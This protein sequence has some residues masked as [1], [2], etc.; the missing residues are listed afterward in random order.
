MGLENFHPLIQRWFRSR[1]AGP[2]EPQLHGWPHIA[3]GRHTLIAAPTGMGKTLTAFLAAIDRLLKQ[4][5]AGENADVLRV[6]YISP[7]RALSNDMQR[8]L[9]GPL[10]EIFSLAE[11]EGLE[12][13]PIRVGLRTG[14]TSAS[15]RAALTRRPPQIL[16][17]TP[18][19]L[20][21]LLTGKRSRDKLRHVETVIVDEIHALVRDKR[22]S[23]LAVSL[24]RL[25]QLCERPPQRVGLSATQRPIEVT[26]AFLIGM[27][28][29]H[30]TAD[31][32]THTGQPDDNPA[33]STTCRVLVSGDIEGSS[34]KLV[35]VESCEQEAAFPK[36]IR[37][38]P[39]TIQNPLREA[40]LTDLELCANGVAE[41]KASVK[42]ASRKTSRADF[43]PKSKQRSLF[44]W[45]DEPDN[46]DLSLLQTAVAKDL[47]TQVHPDLTG[48][49]P[50]SAITPS[51]NCID[52]CS[53]NGACRNGD[54]PKSDFPNSEIDRNLDPCV[55]V[56][57]GH[58]RKMDLAIEIP[59]TEINT[60]CT[61]EQ[62]QEVNERII[63]LVQQHRSTLI[64]VNT[65]RLAERVTH[66]LTELLGEDLIGSHHGSLSATTR[67]STEQ[68]LKQG[69]LK[70]VVATASLELGL[71]VG[72]VDL[73]IQIGSPRAIATFLQ[74]VGRS[75]HALGLI[76]KGRLFAL[77]RD[78][79]VEAMALM[80]AIKEGI[81]DT[82]VVPD[83]PLDILAQQIVA[84]VAHQE[85]QTDDLFELFR[86]AYPYRSLTREKFNSVI[87]MLSE[88][89]ATTAGRS[90]AYLHHDQVGKRVRARKGAGIAAV[91]GGGAIPEIASYRVVTES[92]RTVV[93]TVDEDFAVESQRGDVFLLGNTSW[94]IMNVR[95]GDVNVVDAG[96]APP[97]IPFW[98]GEAPGRTLELS[99]EVS[100][101]R[102]DLAELVVDPVNAEA[103][104]VSETSCC[105]EAARV[106]VLYIAA[107]KAAIGLVPTHKQVVY[108]RFFDESGGMQLVIHAPF[109]SRITRAWGMSMR[110]R[111]CRSF[112]FELQATADDDGIILSLGPQHSFPLESM[113]TMLN[114]GNARNL[115]EQA[116]LANPMYQTR[117]RWNVIRALQVSRHSGG[118]K[119]P[120]PLLR[121]R[122][123]DLLTAVFPKLTGCKE[124]IIGD[125]P[126][127]DHPL[128]SQT[129]E[130]CLFE[131]L[132]IAGLLQILQKIQTQEIKLVGRDT[133]EPSPFCYELLNANPYAFLDGGELQERR[134]RAVNTRRSL[135][136]ESVSDLGRLDPLAIEQVRREALPLIRDEDELHDA[137]LSRYLFPAE[138]GIPYARLFTRLEKAGRATL[139]TFQRN[140][141]GFQSLSAGAFPGSINCRIFWVTAERLPAIRA[142]YPAAVLHRDLPVPEGVK[143][144]WTDIDARIE[145][146]RGYLDFCGPTTAEFVGH[147]LCL[148][149]NQTFAALEYLEGEGVVLRGRFTHQLT[150]KVSAEF[151]TE[152]AHTGNTLV[153]S[154]NDRETA[155]VEWC[156]RRLLSRIHRLTLEGLRKEI[157]PVSVETYM[158]FLTRHQCLY[159]S[160]KLTGTNG[161]FQV[162]SQLQGLDLPAIGWE[163]DLLPARLEKYETGWLDEL[164]LTGEIGWG[165]LFPPKRDAD[166]S[167]PMA[168]ITRVAPISL[169]LRED[170]HFLSASSPE[171]DPATL[172]SPGQEVLELL[173]ERGAM[174][175][176]D[177]LTATRLLPTQLDDVLGELITH[178]FLAADGFSGLRRLIADKSAAHNRDQHGFRRGGVKTRTSHNGVGRWSLWRSRNITAM[179]VDES[180]QQWAWQLIRRWGV[181]FRELLTR[182]H[183]APKWFELVQVY[184]RLE[185]RGEI[186]GGRFIKGV[187]G[188]QFALGDTIRSLRSLREDSQAQELV[189][190]SAADPLNLVGIITE[191]PRVTSTA[192]NRVVYWNGEPLVA[193]QGGTLI[194]YREVP[195]EL[196]PIL[197]DRLNAELLNDSEPVR[198]QDS[199]LT[200]TD[201]VL[202]AGQPRELVVQLASVPHTLP[203]ER[204]RMNST[205][206][207]ALSAL[208]KVLPADE[209]LST[210]PKMGQIDSSA[211]L[212]I[213]EGAADAASSNVGSKS[214]S[215]KKSK[216]ASFPN[217]PN[218]IV[219]PRIS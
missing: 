16:V 84:E 101:L 66:Q 60:V 47:N 210:L 105:A 207:V 120:P 154:E 208:A 102:E 10:Q 159:G 99:A 72:A 77:T 49:Y 39:H 205:L 202:P 4:A 40:G 114:P 145:L 113:F 153:D 171:L 29:L 88:G 58:R 100:R 189:V 71:D 178:G 152:A 92:E 24:E 185:A 187:A 138:E 76:P 184:R 186:R 161:V 128:A 111:F 15:E 126:V 108:E 180:I 31:L 62:W 197:R 81:L 36:N 95:G 147:L 14:D 48:S 200:S 140:S 83:G 156:H 22:G 104:V 55:I 20:Y 131:P 51:S 182:E 46:Q 2:T 133:R 130:D 167:R 3:S 165:R 151:E 69:E 33:S 97:T 157:E 54:L 163:R 112:D 195:P 98:F 146:V 82:V 181:I 141:A 19:S 79:L 192:S 164:C 56:D 211:S 168:S 213:D 34:Q 17:T 21:L 129:M 25:T 89:I 155:T 65:R 177:I 125:I 30:R 144:D 173:L 110:K 115:L 190:I 103:W 27:R 135:T 175:A 121:F 23:H 9:Q 212:S 37:Q 74:R 194:R 6:I 94:R 5:I 12:I 179:P 117:W 199:V 43:Q 215:K 44:R 132:D 119:V 26:A 148:P 137:L 217:Y 59:K 75:G 18:E 28:H 139:V 162:L 158:R 214:L 109:G 32:N 45:D 80:R 64:F 203:N 106:V 61:H 176:A 52:R 150:A 91:M 38:Q 166:R 127:P 70:A 118:K 123:D 149:D 107:Q 169:F 218:S 209:P 143:G 134:A 42:P 206:P 50:S 122:S 116:V 67:H 124:E 170:I 188:E 1:F 136:V 174:F 63:E 160:Q 35:T 183:G 193:L 53:D 8:N 13:A 86:G 57:V 216:P 142:A 172:S 85:W 90:R 96:G 7:L 191:H 219:R 41:L 78:E 204:D 198:V 68:R 87:H 11:Q 93:G 196:E 201:H 73:V